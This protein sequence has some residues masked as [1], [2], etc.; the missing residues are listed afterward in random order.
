M[1]I[2]NNF[3]D[4]FNIVMKVTAVSLFTHLFQ[5]KV[6]WKTAVVDLIHQQNRIFQELQLL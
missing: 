3:T 2:D 5:Q 1:K 6:C 4:K